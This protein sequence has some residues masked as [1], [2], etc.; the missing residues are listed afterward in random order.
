MLIGILPLARSTF[1]TALAQEKC[2]SAVAALESS[3]ADIV[4][5]RH[6]LLDE[7]AF[8]SALEELKAAPIDHIVIL[9]TTFT[10]AA[11]VVTA[12]EELAA[13]LTIWALPEPRTGGRLRLNSLC[14][15]NLAAHALGLRGFHFNW[16]YEDP[17]IVSAEDLMRRLMNPEKT[18]LA[19]A[20]AG[21]ADGR[22]KSFPIRNA[23]IGRIGEHPP[24]FDTCAF[25]EA[26][27]QTRY[28][29]RLAELPLRELFRKADGSA[30]S[31][32]CIEGLKGVGEMEPEALSRSLR[33]KPA[34]QQLASEHRLDAIAIRCW[35]ECFTDYGGAVCAAV[36]LLGDEGIPCACEADVFGAMSQL[37]LQRIA[38]AP[39][40]LTDL[41]EADAEDNSAVV[42][43]CGQAPLSMCDAEFKPRAAVHSNRRQ[44]LLCEFPLKP[45]PVTLMRL[46]QACGDHRLVVMKAE[47]LRRPPAF[48][49][50]SGVLRFHKPVELV[51]NAIIEHRLEHHFALSYGDHVQGLKMAA[52]SMGLQ[53]LEI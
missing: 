42:W 20:K 37:L 49:G 15:L 28:G 44:P 3:G 8:Q 13:P 2:L 51:L 29:V 23:R 50:T 5:C 19:P 6:L 26:Q 18:P 38:D 21:E 30:V 22:G 52:G 11:S 9:Q 31:S 41:V 53:V 24:G 48:S 46:S 32:N 1:D 36:S 33:L 25:D 10:D 12:S 27:L 7:E 17:D 35:P 47:M 34:L 43:H 45:G 40:F 39:V 16:L 4:G 14:G